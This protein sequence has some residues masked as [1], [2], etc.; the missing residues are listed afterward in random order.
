MAD[1]VT[2]GETMLRLSPPRGE[3]LG[4]AGELSATVGG[5]ES[6]VAVAAARLGVD[7]AWLSKLPDSPLGRR[8]VGSLRR[9]GV[10]PRVAW[11]D[12]GRLGVYY[13]EGGR[14]PRGT[15]VLYDRAGS[16]ITTVT[17][18]ELPTDALDGS[19]AFHVTGIT[20][21]LSERAAETTA[22][23]LRRAGGAGAVRTFD[24]NYRSKLWEPSTARAACEALFPAV[25]TLFVPIRDARRVL[26][27]EGDPVEVAH[28]LATEFGFRTVVV[29]RGEAGALAL[30]DGEIHEQ[31]A[32]EAET[33]DPV[34]GGDA[35]VAGFLAARLD[36]AAVPDA[37]ERAA[38][39]AALQRT[40]SGD[41]AVVT[42]ADVDRVVEGGDRID[43]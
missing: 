35:F 39:T 5:A 14:E 1:L 40:L 8:V 25:E 31:P 34:G 26:D 41:A 28:G 9:H 21:A 33:V 18:E 29:T 6:N 16:A 2:F 10:R 24:L 23:L 20:P 42:P 32:F 3:R 38:A 43:R 12:D 22:A 17:A 11:S 30:A 19:S 27:R 13:L 15:S 4:T 7:A 37:L 36:G